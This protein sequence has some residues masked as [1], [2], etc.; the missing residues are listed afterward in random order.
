M[1]T[2]QWVDQ[3]WTLDQANPMQGAQCANKNSV[4]QK[5]PIAAL[6]TDC[7]DLPYARTI[8]G[9]RLSVNLNYGQP[10]GSTSGRVAAWQA[11]ISARFGIQL[12]F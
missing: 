3:T 9:R 6:Q 2:V 11:P 5:N 1:Q 10:G 4:T 7:P 12:S 8:D